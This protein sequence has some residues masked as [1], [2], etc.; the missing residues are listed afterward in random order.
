MLIG[1]INHAYHLISKYSVQSTF[2]YFTSVSLTPSFSLGGEYIMMRLSSDPSSADDAS[3]L[4]SF[5][6]GLLSTVVHLVFWRISLVVSN[7]LFLPGV[8]SLLTLSPV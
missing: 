5:L 4:Q 8:S 7:Y 1:P 6:D 3:K 2:I